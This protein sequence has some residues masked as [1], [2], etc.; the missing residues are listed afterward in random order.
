MKIREELIKLGFEPTQKLKS[1][2]NFINYKKQE[3]SIYL[4][5][6]GSFSLDLESPKDFITIADFEQNEI[7]VFKK[8]WP[9]I[10]RTE[11]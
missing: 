10:L 1:A 6:D 11:N 3:Y 5:K 9:I 4:Y 2:E 7:E 8:L